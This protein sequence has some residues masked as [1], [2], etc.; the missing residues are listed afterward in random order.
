MSSALTEEPRLENISPKAYEH[1]ADRAATA[2][3]AAIPMLDTVVRKLIEYQYER[4]LR[5]LYL[6]NSVRLGTTQL[7]DTHAQY[8]R[9]HRAL[10]VPGEQGLYV[11]SF[12]IAQAGA[13]G[14]QEPIIVLA[15]GLLEVLDLDEQRVVIGHELGHVLSDHMLYRTA[16][17]ILLG[18]TSAARVPLLAGLPLMA[19]RTVLLE[20]S[21]AAELSC[22]RAAVL[23]VRDPQ[24][25]CRTLMVV[26][27]GL[28]SSRL[29]LDAFLSQA[30]DYADWS[31]PHDRTRRFFL[32]L[33]ATHGYAV[34]RASE[35]M[36]WVHSGDYDR[37]IGGDY[38]RRG[39]E[40]PLREAAGDAVDFYA[41]RFRTLFREAGDN[42]AG[43]A[44]QVGDWLRGRSGADE[45]RGEPAD[46]PDAADADGA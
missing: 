37:I 24:L 33:N 5:Q 42:I 25:T 18:L 32:E 7:P 6:G 39:N 44:Q 17:G 46:P 26:S 1:P 28:P 13:I 27:G 11:T 8:L 23:A 30:R 19:V 22:D 40:P 2:A 3:L 21:R 35:V 20:W 29:S 10:D 9:A 14:A 38:I 15:S 36:A 34:R 12:P 31:D 4:T 41:E 43:V 45:A 16:L